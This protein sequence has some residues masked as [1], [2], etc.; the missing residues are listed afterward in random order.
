MNAT[1]QRLID[2][3]FELFGRNGFHAVGI[4]RIYETVGVSKQTFYNHFEG[5]DELILAVLDHRHRMQSEMIEQ[6]LRDIGGDDPR[7][8][9]YGLFEALGAWFSDPDWKGCIFST[10]AAEFPL[11]SEPAHQAAEAHLRATQERL[12]Y[13]A[14]L[15]GAIRPKALAEQLMMLVEGIVAYRHVTADPRSV[16]IASQIGQMLLDRHLP[17]DPLDDAPVPARAGSYQN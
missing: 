4:D 1:R 2:A 7:A 9:L 14:T 16:E 17:S 15:A 6:L 11:K 5:K 10:A 8:Q 3:A 12:Q 13:L